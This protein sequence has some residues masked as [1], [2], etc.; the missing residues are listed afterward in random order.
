M[1]MEAQTAEAPVTKRKRGRPK[2]PQAQ[3]TVISR[4]EDWEQFV[5]QM[6][7]EGKSPGEEIGR[8]LLDRQLGKP[9]DPDNFARTTKNK[10]DM[11]LR[12]AK[13]QLDLA[14]EQK[15]QAEVT[16][17]CERAFPGLQEQKNRA[18]EREKTYRDLLAQTKKI[19]TPAEF[20]I[21]MMCLHPDG[22]RTSEKL[23]EAFRLFF[24]RK[25]ALTGESD[26]KK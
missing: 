5:I 21:I 4:Q 14:F 24:G 26:P 12:Q 3:R 8:M 1:T 2:K 11:A 10:F 15:V 20:N 18:Y 25:F 22:T 16:R 7:A 13:R 19:F 9:V 17:R 23:A 6:K